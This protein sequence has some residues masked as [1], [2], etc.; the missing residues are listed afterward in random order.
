MLLQTMNSTIIETLHGDYKVMSQIYEAAQFSN[1]V[2]NIVSNAKS[3][4]T[5]LQLQ[6]G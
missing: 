2:Y 1:Q 6:P 3:N 5:L 4:K